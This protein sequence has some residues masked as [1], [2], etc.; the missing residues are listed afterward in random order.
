MIMSSL[1][2][3]CTFSLAFD[4][5]DIV[6]YD[7]RATTVVVCNKNNEA[8]KQWRCL[9]ETGTTRNRSYSDLGGDHGVRVKLR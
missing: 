5:T 3:Q 2:F 6:V 8:M 7:N 4:I 1:S 9:E